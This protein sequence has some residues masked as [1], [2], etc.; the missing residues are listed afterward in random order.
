M[1]KIKAELNNQTIMETD[2]KQSGNNLHVEESSKGKKKKKNELT[3]GIQDV[4]SVHQVYIF[5]LMRE[6]QEN[7]KNGERARLEWGRKKVRKEGKKKRY[8]KV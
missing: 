4:D 1:W 8:L 6:L 3:S 5:T 2:R 7:L